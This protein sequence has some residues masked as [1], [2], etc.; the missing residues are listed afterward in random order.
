M[1]LVLY[2]VVVFTSTNNA[3]VA[4]ATTTIYYYTTVNEI[5]WRRNSTVNVFVYAI[6]E[7]YTNDNR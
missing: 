1:P 2:I 4:A 3:V 6:F 5:S 7:R